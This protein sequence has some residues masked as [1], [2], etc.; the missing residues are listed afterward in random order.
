MTSICIRMGL[1]LD[2]LVLVYFYN[3]ARPKIIG[4]TS[5]VKEKLQPQAKH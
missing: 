1:D 4:K 3:H 2:G 5:Q